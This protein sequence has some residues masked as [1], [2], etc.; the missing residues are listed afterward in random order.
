MVS[1]LLFSPH[2][3]FPQAAFP[4]RRFLTPAWLDF[5]IGVGLKNKLTAEVF[6]EC[7]RKVQSLAS[8]LGLL[9]SV[10][11]PSLSLQPDSKAKGESK[12]GTISL[13]PAVSPVSAP[14][15]LTAA[16]KAQR[17]ASLAKVANR[18]V[19]YLWSH[20]TELSAPRFWFALISL[21]NS[22]N[23]F[24]FLH[25]ASIIDVAFV[26]TA[27]KGKSLHLC[28]VQSSLFAFL[29]ALLYSFVTKTWL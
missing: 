28:L 1:C 27:F 5:L 17:A 15:S 25:R 26:P 13:Q 2:A 6:T 16:E 29:Q 22:S 4:A 12:R 3:C 24:L 14:S 11:A 20:F 21:C 18:L 10:T 8:S 9:N 7:A 23:R 19:D